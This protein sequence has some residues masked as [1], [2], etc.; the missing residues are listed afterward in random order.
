MVCLWWE[1][2]RDWRCLVG[3]YYYDG[4]IEKVIEV[5]IN[6]T[7]L[8]KPRYFFSQNRKDRSR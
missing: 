1:A 6:R 2:S 3:T 7:Q 8:E 4:L 5:G